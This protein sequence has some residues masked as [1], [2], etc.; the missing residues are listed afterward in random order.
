M[1]YIQVEVIF[2]NLL[3]Q[4]DELILSI[5][6]RIPDVDAGCFRVRLLSLFETFNAN[7]TGFAASSFSLGLLANLLKEYAEF[8]MQSVDS[9]GIPEILTT[10]TTWGDIPDKPETFP[11]DIHSHPWSQITYKPVLFS[12]A[13]HTHPA[14]VVEWEDVTDKP[15]T[16]TP[17]THAHDYASITDKPETF[18]PATHAHDYASI[19][20]K[21]ATFT[22]ATHAHDYASITDKPTTFTPATHAHDY[23]SITD[24]PTTFTPATHAHDYASITF[25][26]ETF[27]PDNHTHAVFW[28]D[29]QEKQASYPPSPHSHNIA[30]GEISS[31]PAYVRNVT[32]VTWTG[33][34]T[35]GRTITLPYAPSFCLLNSDAS[36]PINGRIR[37]NGTLLKHAGGSIVNAVSFN[38]L[39]MTLNDAGLNQTGIFYVIDVY[40]MAV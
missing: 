28:V 1:N 10:V 24:K 29:V 2:L 36:T 35:T 13:E 40:S 37:G 31:K 27:P 20:D 30:W 12:P 33:D 8:K 9:V 18:T 23:A 22:P 25:K 39:V 3:R 38:D 4:T 21:P 5:I 7:K 11:P 32:G 17:A 14:Q 26:P 15:A 34:G 19:T 6:G 16:F